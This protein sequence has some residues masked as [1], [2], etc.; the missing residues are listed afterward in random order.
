MTAA[1]PT[2]PARPT[3]DRILC[4]PMPPETMSPGGILLPQSFAKRPRA[5][6]VID[7]GPGR[8]NPDQACLD[9]I[10]DLIGHTLLCGDIVVYGEHSGIELSLGTED[11]VILAAQE[12]LLIIDGPH[13][14]EDATT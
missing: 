4:R 13:R 8:W 7:Q 1:L 12:I 2:G 10:D 6:M 14:Q 9:A 11:Y 3:G 5:A